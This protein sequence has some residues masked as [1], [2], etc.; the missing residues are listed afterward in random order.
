MRKRFLSLFVVMALLLS[1]VSMVAVSAAAADGS[2]AEE[3]SPA[4][5]LT[6]TEGGDVET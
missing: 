6:M 3:R 2:S 4:T 5:T 1:M